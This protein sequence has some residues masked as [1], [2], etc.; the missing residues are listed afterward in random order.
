MMAERVTT[1][2]RWLGLYRYRYV[3]FLVAALGL[4][5]ASLQGKSAPTDIL[6]QSTTDSQGELA[7]CG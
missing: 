6:I 4:A 2:G 7:P 3:L 1:E 5:S